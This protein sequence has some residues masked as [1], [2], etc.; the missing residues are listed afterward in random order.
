MKCHATS[1]ETCQACGKTI[2]GDIH[3]FTDDPTSAFCSVDCQLSKTTVEVR[4]LE[5]LPIT[6]PLPRR[7]VYQ[8]PTAQ[9]LD[10][11][12]LCECAVQYENEIIVPN[13]HSVI[14]LCPRCGCVTQD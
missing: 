11:E 2:T 5:L 14:C 13:G 6:E 10:Y 8:G 9:H 3:R 7:P 4:E 1:P 12:R